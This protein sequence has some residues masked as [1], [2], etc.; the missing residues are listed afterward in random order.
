MIFY[1]LFRNQEYFSYII[2][3]FFG[4]INFF[5]IQDPFESFFTNYDQ[6][7]WNTYNSLLIYSGLEQE[8]YDEPGHISYLLFAIYLKIINFFKI[9]DVPTIY[10]I[11][12][13]EN[14]PEKVETLI[15]HSRLFGLVVN[16][17]LTFITIKLFKKFDAKNLI[18]I[19]LI[20]VT[21]NGFLTHTS[22]YRIEPMTLLLFLISMITF[23]NLIE[24]QNKTF[25][26]L[27]LFNFFIIL[28]IINKVQIIFY[29]PFFL[30]ILLNYKK[31]NFFLKKNVQILIRNKKNLFY[32]FSSSFVVIFAIFLR[33]EQI[34][35]SIYLTSMYLIFLLS[36]YSIKE[37]KNN[38]KI[39]YKFNISLFLS[40]LIIYLLVT[41][42]TYGGKNTF[43]VFFKIS[44]IRG[45][46]GDP[47]LDQKYDTFLWIKDFIIFSFKNFL[48][49]FLEI[50]KF[51]ANN[52][53]LFLVIFLTIFS[54]EIK[55]Y[56]R[57]NIFI[58]VYLLTKFIT[59]F[60]ANMF[61]YEIYFDWLI[62][63][64]LIIF[65]NNFKLKT[66]FI[67]F[68]FIII[69]LTN[70]FTNFNQKNLSLINSGSYNVENYCSEK[71]IYAEMGVWSYYSER[72]SKKQILS[73]CGL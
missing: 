12:E 50:L 21:S 46:L 45:Y 41:N 51:K 25:I 59:L 43:W 63:L 8:K 44:K 3:L 29:I 67:N 30:L 27:C 17:I 19:T 73:L 56:L 71:Q 11:N 31:F 20:L 37:I 40:F 42:L 49:L 26:K 22:Q 68:F 36:F 33:S 23:I 14:I 15:F 24:S 58:G 55:R 60:R 32:F 10:I 6:E 61:Y 57:L 64:G 35:S 28:S 53:I 65:F 69:I 4:L 66:K 16:L 39:L 34:H 62:L 13:I 54:R 1:K 18:F 7:F 47:L 70:L 48:Y 2:V 9:I 38:E 72:I 52:L 5:F